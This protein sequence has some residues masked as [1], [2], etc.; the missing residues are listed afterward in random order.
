MKTVLCVICLLLVG[1]SCQS[2]RKI[3]SRAKVWYNPKRTFE[4]CC[5]DFIECDHEAVRRSYSSIGV[6]NVSLR[7]IL[8]SNCME[9]SGYELVPVKQIPAETRR[10]STGYGNW[11]VAGR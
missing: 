2:E 1:G 10:V 6:G 9:A 4:Q 5:K 11:E 8:C 7:V 3:S